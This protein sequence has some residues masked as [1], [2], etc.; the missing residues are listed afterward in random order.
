MKWVIASN[1]RGENCIFLLKV[2]SVMMDIKE[3]KITCGY[4]NNFFFA[5]IFGTNSWGY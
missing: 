5:S 2:S 3:I 4:I 1:R